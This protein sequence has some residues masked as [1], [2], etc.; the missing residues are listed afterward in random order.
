M[1]VPTD[2][3][4]LNM[5]RIKLCLVHDQNEIVS[6]ISYYF[7]FEI[8]RKTAFLSEYY[9]AFQN[10]GGNKLT[11]FLSSSENSIIQINK[12]M[13]LTNF[14]RKKVELT[15]FIFVLVGTNLNSGY[16]RKIVDVFTFRMK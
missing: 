7:L 11:I 2:N 15:I 6:T 5:N 8:K 12:I 1:I 3:F 10:I 4:L 9:K 14:N 13:F 16:F